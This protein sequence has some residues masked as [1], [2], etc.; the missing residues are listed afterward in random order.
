[1]EDWGPSLILVLSFGVFLVFQLS[2][3][4]PILQTSKL[5]PSWLDF[6]A[7]AQPVPPSEYITVTLGSLLLMVASCY[8][9]QLLKLKVP[10]IELEKSA[11][12]DQITT[13][14]PVG[15]SKPT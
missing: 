2:M 14:G 4:G 9:P 15:I 13:L 5:L 8:L 10:G 6:L 11:A 3:L 1:M 7:Q 12:V